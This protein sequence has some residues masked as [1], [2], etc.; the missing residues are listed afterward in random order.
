VIVL[1]ALRIAALV[2]IAAIFQVSAAPQ[3]TPTDSTPD[4]VL[5][6]VVMLAAHRGPETAAIAGFAGGLLVDSVT[7]GWMGLSSLLYVAAGWAIGRRV[8][9]GEDLIIGPSG[10][11]QVGFR[12]EF[13]YTVLAAVGVQVGY[14]VLQGLLGEGL[15][16]GFTVDHIIVPAIILTIVFALPL[17]PL[18]RRLLHSRTRIDAAR[19][20]PA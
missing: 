19:T 6:L 8:Q 1:D 12:S 3:L 5:I 13:G 17:L 2:L 11:S 7:G 18:L 4:L 20:A 10:S 14:A 16:L 15:P 9:G